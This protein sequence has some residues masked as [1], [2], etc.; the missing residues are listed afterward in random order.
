V[1]RRLSYKSGHPHL[2][3]EI[4]SVFQNLGVAYTVL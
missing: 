1:L 4:N 2:I 3:T